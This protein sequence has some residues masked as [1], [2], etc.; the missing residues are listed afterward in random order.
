M[1]INFFFEVLIGG[2]LSGVMYALVAIGFVLIYKASGVFNFAQGAMVFFAA[3]T[4]VGIMDKFGLSLWLAIPLTML[5]MIVLGMAIERVVL[6]PLVNQPEI[7]LFMA[8]IGLTFF[9]EGL[10]QLMWGS[11]VHKLDLPIEDVPMPFLMDHFNIIVS[12]FD[13][14]AAGICA[15]LVICLALLFSKTKVGRALRAVADD[16]QAALAVGIPLQR[17]WA[18][19]WGVAGLVAMVAGLLWGAR[20]G[21]QFALT[22]IA[23]KALPVLILGGFTSVPGAI[24]GGL[25]IGASEKLAEVYLGPMVGGG[26][27]GWFP[28]VLA[29]LFLLVRPEGLFGE[30]IIRRI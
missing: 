23:L 5:T 9:I 24:V 26:I 12:Q 1:N 22:F 19:V 17:I 21:V 28:Y 13:V 15:L 18:V 30:K 27:E 7:T 6:R 14:V 8:T 25:I 2:L 29:L 20:N 3:L 16:H 10:A 4:C 11:Q